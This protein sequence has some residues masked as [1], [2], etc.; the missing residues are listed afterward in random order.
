MKLFERIRGL[1]IKDDLSELSAGLPDDPGTDTG[2]FAS[3]GK[4]FGFGGGPTDAVPPVQYIS[5]VGFFMIR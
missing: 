3:M 1:F 5:N 4:A 2:F